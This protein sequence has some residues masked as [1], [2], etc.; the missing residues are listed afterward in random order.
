MVENVAVCAAINAKLMEN[1]AEQ[2]DAANPPE[3]GFKTDQQ[4]E[5]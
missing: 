2:H 5:T 4:E 3:A 1:T